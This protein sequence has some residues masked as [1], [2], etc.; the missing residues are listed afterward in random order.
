MSPAADGNLSQELERN[1]LTQRK[2]EKVLSGIK[3]RKSEGEGKHSYVYY[4]IKLNLLDLQ[5]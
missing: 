5:L 4:L 2:K 3:L 1:R